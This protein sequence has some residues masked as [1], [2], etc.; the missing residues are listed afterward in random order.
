MRSRRTPGIG[1][2]VLLATAVGL[3][4]FRCDGDEPADEP[5]RAPSGARAKAQVTRVVDGDTIEVSLDGR[6][7]DVRYIGVDTPA[8]KRVNLPS[9]RA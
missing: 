8:C 7:E 2:L 1:A 9:G 5:A 4:A 6:A 3:L